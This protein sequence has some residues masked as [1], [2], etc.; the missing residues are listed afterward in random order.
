MFAG[1]EYGSVPLSLNTMRAECAQHLLN[2]ALALLLVLAVVKL[3]GK[4][5]RDAAANVTA[6]L[7]EAVH[8][9]LH[10]LIVLELDIAD[11]GDRSTGRRDILELPLERLLTD[12]AGDWGIDEKPF[13]CAMLGTAIH[14]GRLLLRNRCVP[15]FFPQARAR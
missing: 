3:Q 11:T 2:F 10:E 8:V 1:H 4:P 6:L 14:Q 9:Q 7:A 12:T 15:L 13:C 5:F